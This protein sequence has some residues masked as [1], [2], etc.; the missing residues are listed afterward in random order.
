MTVLILLLVFVGLFALG[1]PIAVCIGASTL[2]TMLMTMAFDPA[3]TTIAQRMA[4]GL[5]SFALLAIPL[6][7]WYGAGRTGV[8]ERNQLHAVWRHF[9]FGCRRDIGD[10]RFHDSR[11]EQGRI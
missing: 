3:V 5:N 11:D 4:G 8:C 1:V 7:S 10:R 6:F 2:A 9:G